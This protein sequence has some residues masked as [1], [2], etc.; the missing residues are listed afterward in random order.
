MQ[1]VNEALVFV[2]G[3]RIG[4]NPDHAVDDGLD[5]AQELGLVGEVEQ[6]VEGAHDLVLETQPDAEQQLFSGR[7]P[8]SARRQRGRR[9]DGRLGGRV[10]SQLLCPFDPFEQRHLPISSSLRRDA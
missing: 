6:L 8:G 7:D 5:P 3:Q 2:M 4:L 1:L 10:V 9:D